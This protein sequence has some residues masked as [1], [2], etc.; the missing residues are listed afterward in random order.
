MLNDWQGEF[1][2]AYTDRNVYSRHRRKGTF[3]WLIPKD[4]STLLEVGCNRGRNLDALFDLGFSVFGVEPNVKA[5]EIAKK[6]GHIVWN[7]SV[8]EMDT[9]RQFDLVFTCGVLMHIPDTELPKAMDTIWQC[10][11]KYALAIEY[12]GPDEEKE[13]RGKYGMLWKRRAYV[14]PGKLIDTGTLS[15]RFDHCHYWLYKKL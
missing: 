4:V 10:A 6:R 13:Y 2:D 12:W 1:G 11:T 14:Y 15:D 5:Y 9:S 8:Q 7:T 3:K